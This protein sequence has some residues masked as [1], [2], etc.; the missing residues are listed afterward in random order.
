MKKRK[1]KKKIIKTTYL[2][3]WW[4]EG[5]SDRPASPRWRLRPRGPAQQTS[6][7]ASPSSRASSRA[8][9]VPLTV[10]AR[11]SVVFHLP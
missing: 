8:L 11:W 3:T 5:P 6:S 10:G 2:L 9:L 4:P 7:R 1:K